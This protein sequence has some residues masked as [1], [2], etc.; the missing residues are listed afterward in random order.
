MLHLPD[1]P[2]GQGV[3]SKAG[4]Q[5]SIIIFLQAMPRLPG[6]LPPKWLE[7]EGWWPEAC[8]LHLSW[9]PSAAPPPHSQ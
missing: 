5:A 7:I 8:A 9:E 3:C 1:S 2:L 4:E 6:L